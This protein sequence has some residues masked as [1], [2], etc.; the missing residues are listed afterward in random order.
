MSNFQQLLH[1]TLIRSTGEERQMAT[2]QF[3]AW[4]K[5]NANAFFYEL[6][7]YLGDNTKPDQAR[8][9]AGMLLKNSLTAEDSQVKSFRE[10]RWKSMPADVKVHIRERAYT[11]MMGSDSMS[12]KSAVQV[13]GRIG[14][15]DINSEWPDLMKMLM[16]ITVSDAS[17]EQKTASLD[18]M[19]FI[20]ED[21]EEL[22]KFSDNL[23]TSAIHN[24]N[25]QGS[26]KLVVS[27]LKALSHGLVFCSENFQKAG[28]R[29]M[30]IKS[31]I[32]A[33]QNQNEEISETAFGILIELVSYYYDHI[34][35]Q[36][37]S[38][39][40]VT[41]DAIQN[42]EEDIAKYAIEFW[43]T[44]CEVEVEK[45][46]EGSHCFH[47]AK[48]ALETII[49]VLCHCLTKQD[50]PEYDSNDI[51]LPIAA[52]I[53]LKF[54]AQCVQEDIIQYLMPFVEQNIH[55]Q[56]WIL[57]DAALLSLIAILEVKS[58]NI[59]Q[60]VTT[61][62]PILLNL[63]ENSSV[64]AIRDN[65]AWTLGQIFKVHPNASFP[66]AN[67][68]FNYMGNALQKESPRIA[69][70][71]CFTIHSMAESFECHPES[72]VMK[73][74]GMLIETLLI[75][76]DRSDS[77]NYNLRSSAYETMIL[78]LLLSP[79][80]CDP[81]FFQLLEEVVRRLESTITHTEDSALGEAAELCCGVIQVIT[82]H[83]REDILPYSER[84]MTA[85]FKLLDSPNG[86][87]VS[88]DA[89]LAITTIEQSL[90]ESFVQYIPQTM[91]FVVNGL[92]NWEDSNACTASTDLLSDI[93]NI[94]GEGINKYS[95]E[96]M[97]ILLNNMKLD[98]G[99]N[100]KTSTIRCFGDFSMSLG[101]Q[102]SRYSYP[103]LEVLHTTTE[104]IVSLDL[105][106]LDYEDQDYVD[107]LRVSLFD[108]YAS[109]ITSASQKEKDLLQESAPNL[110]NLIYMTAKQNYL[111]SDLVCAT[112]GVL[113][114]LVSLFGKSSKNHIHPQLQQF[115]YE[116]MKSSESDIEAEVA[117]RAFDSMRSIGL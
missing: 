109:I 59:N 6:A 26:P 112:W 84:I 53:S 74:Y 114:D 87:Q 45:K 31:I 44:I 1:D 13:I 85:L 79:E 33:C 82:T 111:P 18:A 88:H 32:A 30:I 110:F 96:I 102:F 37:E 68:V 93:V 12:S 15:L 57:Q 38:L 61:A 63:L 106:E 81:I 86:K 35:D 40:K 22:E 117:S 72:P 7:T 8:F 75:T 41:L 4:E 92:K 54:F 17:I 10:E 25:N 103:V 73:H 52:S 98:I 90:N 101:F 34:Q 97:D 71:A 50:D 24:L 14:V 65:S 66:F 83:L 108:T 43:N 21:G 5:E 56:D 42:A 91:K 60:I 47:F 29:D 104:L 67:D 77:I 95:D 100:V 116:A 51:S 19:G 48:A 69:A 113:G 64:V 115:A 94:L 58:A 70:H 9:I 28:E 2:S 76:G 46:K 16:D 11:T 3:D 105:D 99:R 80:G 23:L 107:S 27:A 36:M 39:F 20:F 49:P 78:L 62:I 55:S 89:F